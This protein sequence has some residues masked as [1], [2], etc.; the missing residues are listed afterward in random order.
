M[1][2]NLATLHFFDWKPLINTFKGELP[3]SEHNATFYTISNLFYIHHTF[4]ADLK[5]WVARFQ[6]R[7]HEF[8]LAE[9]KM[10]PGFKKKCAAD[11]VFGLFKIPITVETFWPSCKRKMDLPDYAIH[12]PNMKF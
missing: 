8:V 2:L 9:G 10:K 12:L 1:D 4:N 11:H 3:I 5:D 7:K 6:R